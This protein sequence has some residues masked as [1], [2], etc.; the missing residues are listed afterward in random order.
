M[1][2][3][4]GSDEQMWPRRAPLPV[5]TSASIAEEKVVGS[6]DENF[7]APPTYQSSFGDALCAAL[8]GMTPPSGTSNSGKSKK[9]K[10]PKKKLLFSTSGQHH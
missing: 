7:A 1:L 8:E 2:K 9:G 4:S 5:S 10:K 6:E 3:A